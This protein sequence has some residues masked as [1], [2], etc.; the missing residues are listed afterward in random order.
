MR[1]TD[2]ETDK[3]VTICFPFEE[4]KNKTRQSLKL[5]NAA[6]QL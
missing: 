3:A 5:M 4:H 1:R 6:V 2:G